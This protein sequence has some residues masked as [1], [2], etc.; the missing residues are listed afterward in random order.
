M[1]D[2]EKLTLFMD[3]GTNGEIVLGSREWLVTCACSAGPAFE[4]AG[5][6]HGMRATKGAIEEVWIN[7]DT[8]EP[9]YRVIGGVQPRGLCGSGLISLLSEMFITGVVDK[10][11]N[12]ANHLNTPRIREGEHGMEYVIVWGKDTSH[13]DD[14]F[15]TRV[16][17]DNLLRAKAAIYAGFTILAASVGVN[18]ADVQQFLIGGS[19]GK[20]INVEKAI[21]IGLLPDLP[22]DRF[23]F[24][25]N[26]SVLGAY[27]ALL[28]RD[29]RRRIAEISRMMTYIELSADNSFYDAF[30]AALFLP[31]T[32][33]ARFPSVAEVWDRESRPQAAHN[34][35]KP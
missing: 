2:T 20:Y 16:D 35:V 27:M 3:V 10:A 25:G 24:L 29:S 12:I 1:S 22:W 7:N 14:I 28:S 11:G 17:I 31:H 32:E 4:G 21:Q 6:I 30:T 8:Y 19:F 34:G 13:G 5:V 15:I 18:L 26:T 23:H 33:I 9:T